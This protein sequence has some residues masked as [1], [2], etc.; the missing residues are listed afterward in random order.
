MMSTLPNQPH[1]L[2]KL[3]CLLAVFS[4]LMSC[5]FQL[6]GADPNGASTGLQGL[7]LR[8]ISVQPRSDLTREVSR[9]LSNAGAVLTDATGSALQLTLQAEQFSQRNVS[10]TAQARAAELE[11]TLSVNFV[12]EQTEQD[13]TDAR[14]TVSRQ[15]LNDPRNIVG[16]TEELRLLREEMRRDL[17]AQIVRRIGHSLSR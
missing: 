12:L 6:R 2:A 15:M 5:G 13:P 14:A 3:A 11:L 1:R 4:C 16:K 9:E 17:A 7:E 8:L 10:L